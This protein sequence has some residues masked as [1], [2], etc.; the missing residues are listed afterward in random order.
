MKKFAKLAIVA[1][2]SGVVSG[3]GTSV[4]LV[5]TVKDVKRT[6]DDN[7]DNYLADRKAWFDPERDYDMSEP[8]VPEDLGIADMVKIFG[9]NWL[10]YAAVPTG[11]SVG[12]GIAAGVSGVKEIKAS[13]AAKA[14][15]NASATAT[16][17]F[18]PAA[19]NIDD[20]VVNVNHFIPIKDKPG[21]GILQVADSV[22]HDISAEYGI[23]PVFTDTKSFDALDLTKFWT[24]DNTTFARDTLDLEHVKD[25]SSVLEGIESYI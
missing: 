1:S 24:V 21:Y 23:L 12:F 13:R 25:I 20:V 7:Y 6:N 19:K 9:K 5:K 15:A 14:V 4:A 17:T 10:K 18:T 22:T 8:V 3:I 16:I 2:V 11:V